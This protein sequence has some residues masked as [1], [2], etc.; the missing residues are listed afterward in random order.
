MEA[1]IPAM[2]VWICLQLGCE[3]PPPPDVIFV[4]QE[5][6]LERV[7]GTEPP[8]GPYVCGLYDDQTQAIWLPH[9]CRA[10]DLLDQSTLLHELVHHVQTATAMVYPCPPAR[11]RLAYGLQAQW[12]T[13]KG[14][15]DPYA[16][17]EVDP[18]TIMLRSLC[19]PAE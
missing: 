8:A 3:P 13:E 15:E 1:L 9:D 12:L 16:E 7:Y 2:L 6:L 17:M 5:T 11:E 4:S 19:L 14:I 18:F 10:D